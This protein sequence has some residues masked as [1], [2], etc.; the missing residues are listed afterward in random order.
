MKIL[1]IFIFITIIIS[2][3]DSSAQDK[4]FVFLKDKSDVEFNP[5]E[6][7]D[8]KSIERRLKNSIDLFDISD[9]PLNKTY[10][11]YINEIA[12]STGFQSRWL[13]M[14]VVNAFPYQIEI[15]KNLDFVYNIEEPESI[16]SSIAEISSSM[17]SPEK[18]NIL[19]SQTTSMGG[20]LFEEKDIRGKGIR[21]AIFDIGF[22]HVNTNNV[23]SHIR[24]S[25][26]IIK[27]WDFIEEDENVYDDGT[28]GRSVFS[29]IAG[30]YDSTKIGLATEAEFLLAR[31]EYS[32]KEPFSE[33][34]YWLEAA[35][36]A[37]KNGV[38]IINSS[39]GYTHH[40]YFPFDMNG[41]KSL[42]VRAAN[43]AARKGILVVNSMG[44]DGQGT[45]K[46]MCTPADA[47]SVLSVGGVNYKTGFRTGFSSYGP[48]SDNRRKPNVSAYGIV[49]AAGA[50][51]ISQTQG[52]S[53]SSPLVAGF[54]AC[55]L[56]LNPQMTNMELF[57]EIEKSGN[58]Y[59]YYD[60]SHGY[61]IPQAKYFLSK[62][63]EIN[64]NFEIS[65]VD[66]LITIVVDTTSI[67]EGV[68]NL[69]YYHIENKDGVLAKYAVIDVYEKEAL[70]LMFNEISK[71]QTLRVH[72]KGHTK[73]YTN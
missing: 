13:N 66:D 70:I 43:M 47:D 44:N 39:L 15:I 32:H 26:R 20:D 31:T 63:K 45:W 57:K 23:F 24:D 12:V 21:I 41:N 62:A 60:Y 51:G 68:K 37:D 35:E 18:A 73:E 30:I 16:I 3:I 17:I 5:F 38:D 72:Y 52:T 50:S 56:Q 69:L 53:F 8:V 64:S 54:A 14:V 7:F 27:T 71:G 22:Q 46:V 55:A 4:Y 59:P 58:L 42:V 19:K 36:W 10:I 1:P 65:I 28:H 49:I 29:C 11:N 6:Y 2:T 61:G 33:E 34:E 40:R 48:T 9:Y 67:N 25:G